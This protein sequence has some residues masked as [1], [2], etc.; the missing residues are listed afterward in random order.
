MG[1]ACSMHAEMLKLQSAHQNGN[2]AGG[3]RRDENMMLIGRWLS[4]NA[5]MKIQ[6]SY[7]TEI[8][9]DQFSDYQRLNGL[10]VYSL[11]NSQ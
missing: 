11:Y 4:V 10:A 2:T 8:Y 6:I 5:L 9:L 1:G 7:R 3:V